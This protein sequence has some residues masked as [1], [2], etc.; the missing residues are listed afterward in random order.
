[1]TRGKTKW[2]LVLIYIVSPTWNIP[3]VLALEMQHGYCWKKWLDS[4][5]DYIYQIASIVC[6]YLF[7]I[8]LVTFL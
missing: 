6:Q 5:A 3:Y 1:M 4:S 2:L 8:E 7:P